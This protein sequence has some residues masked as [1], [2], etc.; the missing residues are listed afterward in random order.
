MQRWLIIARVKG[1]GHEAR[2]PRTAGPSLQVCKAMA[3]QP[4]TTQCRH[5]VASYCTDDM[6][7]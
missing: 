3:M 7:L 1:Y 6:K 5:I 2:D 4:E